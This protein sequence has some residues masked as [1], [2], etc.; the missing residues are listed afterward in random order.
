VKLLEYLVNV[1]EDASD[2]VKYKY[3]Y[4]AFQLLA[5]ENSDMINALVRDESVEALLSFFT[6]PINTVCAMYVQPLF[7]KIV[8]RK[9]KKVCQKKY[10][11]CVLFLKVLD[12][13]KEN[14]AIASMIKNIHIYPMVEILT[15]LIDAIDEQLGKR[16]LH[17]V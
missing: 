16:A 5:T 7:R 4:L 9:L 12:W 11:I 8:K 10:I 2:E 3:P 17:E 1:P 13:L 15:D 14:E 6:R